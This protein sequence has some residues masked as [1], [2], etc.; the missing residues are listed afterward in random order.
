MK[1]YGSYLNT[2]LNYLHVDINKIMIP[3]PNQKFI[4][5][6]IIIVFCKKKN[7]INVRNCYFSHGYGYYEIITIV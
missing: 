4:N 1:D 6:K 2:H 7:E 5:V 3:P